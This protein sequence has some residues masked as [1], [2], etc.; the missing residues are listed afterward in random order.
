VPEAL[1]YQVS[2]RNVI[3]KPSPIHWRDNA[4]NRPKT[5]K[6]SPAP[7]ATSHKPQNTN[8]KPQTT[9][10]KPQTQQ[11]NPCSISPNQ[12]VLNNIAANKKKQPI[13]CFF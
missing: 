12:L 3:G 8:H 13:G 4:P 6:V 5:S 11:L 10:H 2:R 1:K 9:N 7:Q